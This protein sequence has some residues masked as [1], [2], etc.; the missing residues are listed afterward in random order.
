L[1][2]ASPNIEMKTEFWTCIQALEAGRSS[3]KSQKVI[4]KAAFAV[5]LDEDVNFA[6]P[7]T[8]K[9]IFALLG[10]MMVNYFDFFAE[11]IKVIVKTHADGKIICLDYYSNLPELAIRSPHSNIMANIQWIIH[12]PSPS[13][14][15]ISLVRLLTVHS[16]LLSFIGPA[17]LTDIFAEACHAL[18]TF[19]QEHKV[20]ILSFMAKLPKPFFRK[21]LMATLDNEEFNIKIGT[22]QEAYSF[23]MRGS[24]LNCLENELAAIRLACLRILA[25]FNS[26]QDFSLLIKLSRLFFYFYNDEDLRIRIF[27]MS[28]D[29]RLKKSTLRRNIDIDILNLKDKVYHYE[30]LAHDKTESIRCLSYKLLSLIKYDYE[31]GLVWFYKTVDIFQNC[32]EQRKKQKDELVKIKKAF[33]KLLKNNS[34]K[35]GKMFID[36]CGTTVKSSIMNFD[37]LENRGPLAFTVA[38]LYFLD[39]NLETFL[40]NGFTVSEETKTVIGHY[41]NAFFSSLRQK[42]LLLATTSQRLATRAKDLFFSE[43]FDSFLRTIETDALSFHSQSNGSDVITSVLSDLA[44]GLTKYFQTPIKNGQSSELELYILMYAKKASVFKFAYLLVELSDLHVEARLLLENLLA[45]LVVIHSLK[46]F[47]RTTDRAKTL[48]TVFIE[49]VMPKFKAI[50]DANLLNMKM[51]AFGLLPANENNKLMKMLAEEINE[52]IAKIKSMESNLQKS[53]CKIKRMQLSLVNSPKTLCQNNAFEIVKFKADFKKGSIGKLPLKMLK[54]INKTETQICEIEAD[55]SEGQTTMIF[56]LN[57]RIDFG[58]ENQSRLL[59]TYRL[60]RQLSEKL[61]YP[62]SNEVAVEFINSATGRTSRSF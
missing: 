42:T 44:D 28:V 19:D 58:P 41:L 39:N 55:S 37:G 24:L 15:T 47:Y 11:A 31:E 25:K 61:A 56:A 32:L 38:V 12:A 20:I 17:D 14:S 13:Q 22:A 48:Q 29:L 62:V 36:K 35:F 54:A 45:L 52:T 7:G 53:S 3:N 4:S 50:F 59:V 33:L 34:G 43:P 9:F 51:K 27:A 16:H 10:Y 46:T 2:V 40:Q 26:D 49:T 60:V 21:H 8:K 18:K 6:N 1:M 57:E 23:S 30:Y 5:I